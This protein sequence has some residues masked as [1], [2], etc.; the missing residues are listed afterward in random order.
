MSLQN[1]N[2]TVGKAIQTVL[3]KADVI[4]KAVDVADEVST[5]ENVTVLDAVT[6]VPLEQAEQK[7]DISYQV[8]LEP[9]NE[10]V[11]E[12]GV[13]ANMLDFLRVNTKSFLENRLQNLD[14][15]S[16]L[17]QNP[18][19]V[20]G[21][22][23]ADSIDVLGRSSTTVA[24]N[25][26]SEQATGNVFINPKGKYTLTA[27]SVNLASDSHLYVRSPQI[28]E[29]TQNYSIQS[30]NSFSLLTSLILNKG[31]N[32]FNDIDNWVQRSVD[33]T[34]VNS[35]TFTSTSK[36]VRQTA[37]E[38]YVSMGKN[39]RSVADNSMEM[40]SANNIIE[41]ARGSKATV[42]GDIQL[43][44]NSTNSTQDVDIAAS[45]EG[46]GVRYADAT[47]NI[48]FASYNSSGTSLFQFKDGDF[49]ISY[50]RDGLILSEGK[51][52]AVSKEMANLATD[53][54]SAGAS[55]NVTVHTGRATHINTYPISV[56]QQ[57]VPNIVNLPS[58][59]RLPKLPTEDLEKCV[60]DKYK[61]NKTGSEDSSVP[62]S[63]TEQPTSSITV[64]NP[65]LNNPISVANFS[66]LNSG[67]KLPSNTTGNEAKELYK[68]PYSSA[69]DVYVKLSLENKDLV[70]DLIRNQ[71]D[72]QA[73]EEELISIKLDSSSLFSE[74]QRSHLINTL[75]IS[76]ARVAELID[77]INRM[78]TQA[79]SVVSKRGDNLLA[80]LKNKTVFTAA[81]FEQL[82]DAEDTQIIVTFLNEFPEARDYIFKNVVLL[83]QAIGLF[84]LNILSN[85]ITSVI[86]K[87]TSFGSI[88]LDV[89]GDRLLDLGK[90]YLQQRITSWIGGTQFSFLLDVANQFLSTGTVNLDNVLRTTVDKGLST[91][92]PS[93]YSSVSLPITN[94]VSSLVQGEEI[95]I[96]KEL[97]SLLTDITP[98]RDITA[99]VEE[100]YS[101]VQ[102]VVTDYESGDLTQLLT[103]VGLQNLL[104]SILGQ[105]NSQQLQRVF[106]IIKDSLGVVE[107]INSLPALLE[108]MRE[109][110]VPVLDQIAIALN[111]LDLF[112]RLTDLL[113]SFK[114]ENTSKLNTARTV[115]NLPRL[116][117]AVNTINQ[118]NNNPSLPTVSLDQFDDDDFVYVDI[119]SG[120][121]VP[122]INLNINLN[123]CFGLPKLTVA[124][125]DVTVDKIENGFLYFKASDALLIQNKIEK[126]VALGDYIHLNVDYFVHPSIGILRPYQTE[127]QYTKAVYKFVIYEY[128]PIQNVGIAALFKESLKINLYSDLGAIYQFPVEAIG[129]TVT[130]VWKDVYINK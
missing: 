21:D 3:Q 5:Y 64:D 39:H 20:N 53:T 122:Q 69:V 107:A 106:N 7:K 75:R 111:C 76:E 128:D 54:F 103:G 40:L 88:G 115:E 112:D 124:E 50:P 63:E 71:T 83:Q 24:K 36:F 80:P 59:P 11:G 74:E 18:A 13:I 61:Q 98:L 89:I 49:S 17:S 58:F 81:D 77:P 127:T 121:P 51:F 4:A 90:S 47:G 23:V 72:I 31:D 9:L 46:D 94:L 84:G 37:T 10:T 35:N 33:S 114:G 97:R 123:K 130:P 32:I 15:I 16:S 34:V 86:K 43:I 42:A 110:N 101:L 92:L 66:L 87:V 19:A 109:Y 41:H 1:V 68:F 62:T 95:D 125:A 67:D 25:A 44:A 56:P 104:S 70:F 99:K 65:Y 28:N 78:I 73:I 52:Q 96:K 79:F 30:N 117:Q 82:L 108:L 14:F 85:P 22:K 48:A 113:S 119:P 100:I 120:Q 105:S 93:E 2:D 129:N 60:P 27:N 8:L 12:E 55:G 91:I 26:V 6:S 116:I 29:H 57:P 126:Q 118:I 102:Q 38:D 45:P